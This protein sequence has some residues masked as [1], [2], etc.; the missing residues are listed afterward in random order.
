MS[1]TLTAGDLEK[2]RRADLLWT[3]DA[4]GHAVMCGDLNGDSVHETPALQELLFGDP[5]GSMLRAQLLAS[6]DALCGIARASA[7]GSRDATLATVTE[8]RTN[9]ARY[10][11]RTT[12]CGGALDGRT[13]LI[14][15]TMERLIRATVCEDA[16]RRAFGLTRAEARVAALIA[17][18][19][20]N[21]KLAEELSISPHTARRHTE[22]VLQK[23]NV[24]SRAGISERVLA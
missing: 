16:L 14:L 10:S 5:Q 13:P 20:P 6:L 23:L 3:L 24:R 4:L 12:V 7:L 21:A 1:I 17:L 22:R 15:V 18:G 9:L 8:V 19:Q 11:I 2:L